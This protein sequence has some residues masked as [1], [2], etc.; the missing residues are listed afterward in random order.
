[1]ATEREREMVEKIYEMVTAMEKKV[2]K[3]DGRV[4]SLESKVDDLKNVHTGLQATFEKG[5]SDVRKS[6][7]EIIEINKNRKPA[8]EIV[9]EIAGKG[10]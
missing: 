9:E 2:D 10:K 1:M 4:T 6:L 5:F 7:N 3:L 8:R